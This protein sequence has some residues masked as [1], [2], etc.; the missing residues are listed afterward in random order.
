MIVLAYLTDPPT[1]RR[2][3]DHLGVPRVTPPRPVATSRLLPLHDDTSPVTDP[4]PLYDAVDPPP[5]PD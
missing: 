3:L 4:L 1:V 5:P 2:I